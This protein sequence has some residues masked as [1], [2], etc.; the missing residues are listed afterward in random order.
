M[1][2]PEKRHIA[3]W[4]AHNGKRIT[5]FVNYL[6]LEQITEFVAPKIEI[7]RAT[8]DRLV[9]T[10]AAKFDAGKADE[11]GCVRL[12]DGD[13]PALTWPRD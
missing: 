10:A 9:T 3:F 8:Q 5:A 6:L 1:D 11:M 12:D 13:M 4:I 2:V 7:F